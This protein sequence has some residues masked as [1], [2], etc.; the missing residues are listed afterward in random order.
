MTKSFLGVDL[1]ATS[2]KI[3][4][5]KE[6]AGRPR[7]LT[8]GYTEQSVGYPEKE[9]TEIPERAIDLIKKICVKSKTVSKQAVA[10]LPSASVFSSVINIPAAPGKDLAEAVRWEAKKIIPLPLEEMILDWKV[11]TPEAAVG[12][13]VPAVPQKTTRVLLTAAA[14]KLV[15]K[16]LDIFK[17]AGLNLVS[18]ET[19]TFALVRALVGVD[20]STV[21][22]V[23]MG[24]AST[25]ISIIENGVPF[26]NR[27]LNVGGI[28]ITKEISTSL[29]IDFNQA[30]QMKYDAGMSPSAGG[31]VSKIVER[32]L[33]M[34]LNEIKYCTNL[35]QNQEG[36]TG[37]K[38]EKIILTGGGALLPNFV[39]YLSGALNMRVYAGNPWA[40][41]IYPEELRPILDQVG[42]KFS[43]AIGLAMRELE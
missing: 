43:V 42:P 31:G 11:L 21:I 7:L 9:F 10:A 6:E 2:I 3:V 16:Y 14:K 19:E 30:E 26:L 8:Y 24:A 29:G 22:V 35:Y 39:E 18:L 34:L 13:A 4:E 28:N 1:G 20:K 40:R 15:K 32:A 17:G 27:S 23:D 38:I 33:T 36:G 12:A 5:L 41:I 25:A 37:K